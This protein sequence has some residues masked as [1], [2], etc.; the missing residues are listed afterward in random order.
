MTDQARIAA[1][2]PV[3]IVALTLYGEARGNSPGLRTAIASVILNRV[4][5]QHHAFGLTAAEVCLKPWQFSC[6]KVEG[7]AANHQTV[8]D[9]A[10]HLL[11]GAAIG[12]VLRG[13][14]ALGVEVCTGTLADTVH[15][16]THY[17]SPAAMVPRDRI[18]SWAVGLEPVA[19]IDSTRFYR[20]W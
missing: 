18:P 6:W 8:M 16:A 19:I 2:S 12:P 1:L 10:G 20:S 5:V 14:L 11:N 15:G 7:G 17:Y 3:Q 9:A 13:C 4:K